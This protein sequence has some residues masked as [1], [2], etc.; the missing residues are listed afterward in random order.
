MCEIFGISARHP[1]VINSY[2]NQ[3]YE[4]SVRHPHGWGLACFEEQEVA[5]EKEP[6][7]ATKS[8][9]LKERL[10]VDISVSA[11]LAHIRYAT[12]GNTEYRNCH[13]YTQKD[14][15]GRRWTQV[16]NGT[17]FEYEPMNKYVFLQKGTTDS[18]RILLYIVDEMNQEILQKGRALTAEERFDVLDSIVVRLSEGNK[19]N[20][21][22]FD[23]EMMY[24]HSNY[25]KSL[26][27]MRMKECTMF[28]SQP[29]SEYGW[30]VVPQNVLMAYQDGRPVFRGTEHGHTYIDNE[31][32]LKYIFQAYSN[33]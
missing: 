25:E 16:H 17:I 31:E 27:Y 26:H 24:A 4:H 8:Y 6:I 1:Q 13:P 20:L 18:E 22:I 2:L 28:A 21:L 19:L 30:E 15:S 10:S 14:D 12:I 7:Q 33:L 3:F 23:G 5:I 9:Y 32:D 11:A 29:L